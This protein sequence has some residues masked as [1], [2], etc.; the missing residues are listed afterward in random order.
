[1]LGPPD[2]PSSLVLANRCLSW[3]QLHSHT[4]LFNYTQMTGHNMSCHCTTHRCD[5]GL[6]QSHAAKCILFC[7]QSLRSHDKL[8]MHVVTRHNKTCLTHDDTVTYTCTPPLPSLPFTHSCDRS[9]L[10]IPP[11]TFLS[12]RRPPLIGH[13]LHTWSEG[14]EGA[15]GRCVVTAV[16]H[17]QATTEGPHNIY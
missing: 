6:I 1:M 4:S 12:T 16:E 9:E 14:W 7:S 10:C 2:P 13:T 11:V 3:L 8:H 5:A 15:G 17:S